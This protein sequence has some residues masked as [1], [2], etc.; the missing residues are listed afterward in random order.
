MSKIRD[1]IFPNMIPFIQS[2]EKTITG[3]I[4]QAFDGI[5]SVF[6]SKDEFVGY[7]NSFDSPNTAESFIKICK[8]HSIAKRYQ[9]TSYVKLIM[10]L[11]AIEKITNKDRP[12]VEF[13]FWITSQREK[14]KE[15]LLK[16]DKITEKEFKKI[17]EKL[18]EEYFSEYGSSRNVLDFFQKYLSTKEK[19]L[20]VRSIEAKWTKIIPEFS[21]TIPLYKTLDELKNIEEAGNR[22]T[23]EVR[24]SLVP[25]CYDWK[26][27]WINVSCNPSI[28]CPLQEDA[29]KLKNTLKKVVGDIYQMRN[30]FVHNAKVVPL[31]DDKGFGTLGVLGKKRKPI[32]IKLTSKDLDILFESGLK[33]YFDNFTN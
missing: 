30:D 25:Y 22:T 27:C 7:I 14:I 33:T 8:F 18:R 24:M 32:S 26:R 11:S 2:R 9:S 6:S 16:K 3:Y 19:L 5:A 12:Y 29:D 20:L 4:D 23:K 17:I 28:S 1:D 13:C 15:E 21:T 31:A 10:I